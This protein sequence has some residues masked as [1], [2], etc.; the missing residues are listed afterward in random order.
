MRFLSLIHFLTLSCVSSSSTKSDSSSSSYVSTPTASCETDPTGFTPQYS[1][2]SSNTTGQCVDY[3]EGFD[4]STM[5]VTCLT[6]QGNV[7]VSVG[8]DLTNEIGRCCQLM[9]EQWFVTHYLEGNSSGLEAT[10]LQAFCE[11]AEG[12]W[13]Q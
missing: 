13:F 2:D 8:C 6:L 1:C 11:D 3:L 9:N 12:S 7:S 10:E 5:D 4:S